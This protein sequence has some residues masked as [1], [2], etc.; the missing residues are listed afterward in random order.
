MLKM[1]KI[2]VEIKANS[3]DDFEQTNI[4]EIEVKDKIKKENVLVEALKS[5]ELDIYL[6]N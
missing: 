2:S 1:K 3:V 4:E 5:T 6:S